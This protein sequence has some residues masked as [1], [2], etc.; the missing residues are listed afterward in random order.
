MKPTLYL[1]IG[2]GRCGST[3]I[4]RFATEQRGAL[5][6]TRSLYPSPAE[7][8]IDTTNKGNADA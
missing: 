4:Q 2:Q 5:D 6:G 1:H 7:L 3:S 8:G